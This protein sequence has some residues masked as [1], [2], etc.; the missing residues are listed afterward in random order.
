MTHNLPLYHTTPMQ[1]IERL[2]RRRVVQYFARKNMPG[3]ACVAGS[4]GTRL[5]ESLG[6]TY[7][8]PV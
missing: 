6:V 8:L 5:C 2:V 1:Q 4:A 3:K 7:T